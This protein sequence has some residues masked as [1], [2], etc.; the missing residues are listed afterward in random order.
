MSCYLIGGSVCPVVLK[1]MRLIRLFPVLNM[2][3]TGCYDNC[4]PFSSFLVG[5]SL[6][7][8]IETVCQGNN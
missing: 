2:S 1:K 8:F 5:L 4:L 3:L 7:D 6:F